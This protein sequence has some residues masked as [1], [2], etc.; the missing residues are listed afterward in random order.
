LFGRASGLF[1]E[2]IVNI[3]EGLFE[4]KLLFLYSICRHGGLIL[5]L[6]GQHTLGRN[7]NCSFLLFLMIG[8]HFMS[9][10]NKQGELGGS[11]AGQML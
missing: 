9:V 1:P 11:G 6:P 5:S 4:H 7:N 3:F 10:K 2:D 8:W